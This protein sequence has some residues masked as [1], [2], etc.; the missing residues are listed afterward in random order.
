MCGP[1]STSV[2]TH[3][4]TRLESEVSIMAGT[5]SRGRARSGRS[6]RTNKAHALTEAVEFL[7]QPEQNPALRVLAFLIR[8][9]AELFVITILLWSRPSP[10]G[11]RVRVWIPAGLS[12]KDIEDDT[13]RLATACWAR[14]VR[15]T[16]TRHQAALVIVDI[17]RRDPLGTTAVLEPTVL[18]TI[19]HEA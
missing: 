11:E 3:P 10:I 2:P 5:R 1:A 14:E 16:P 17:V 7:T 4:P 15:I 6:G 12:V 19:D 13:Q 9:R 18:D 8:A